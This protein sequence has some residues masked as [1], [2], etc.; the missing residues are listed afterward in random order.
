MNVLIT[1]A[2]GHIGSALVNKL[3]S[4]N[5]IKK[6]IIIDNFSSERYISFIN[7]KN[8]HKILF[9]DEDLANFNLSKIKIKID[10][11]VHLASTTNAEKS[12]LNKKHVL[13]NNVKC[14]KKVLQ[15]AK[16]H[17]KIIFASST[18]VYGNQY[19]VINSHNNQKNISPQSPYA[20]SKILC[21]NVIKKYSKNYCIMRFGTIFGISDGMRFHTAINKFCYQAVLG[22]KITIWK[23]FYDKKRPYLDL[24]DCVRSIIFCIFN[25]EIRNETLDVVTINLKVVDIVKQIEN[26]KQIKKSFVNTKI[27]NQ[28][29]YEV[30]SDRLKN[31]KFKFYGNLFLSIKKM[32]KKLDLKS[33][34]K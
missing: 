34:S 15:I 8:R 32:I 31:L 25:K 12:F 23:K 29:S 33:Y 14:T 16:N 24:N 19:Q 2:M 9:F 10:F 26:L 20:H 18:S 13:D 5:K 17:T 11:I 28:L 4:I 1:G 22:Q 7:L 6:V 27:L 3:S 30:H 21:E